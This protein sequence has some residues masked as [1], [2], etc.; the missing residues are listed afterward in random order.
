MLDGMFDITAMFGFSISERR[1]RGSRVGT[2]R[3]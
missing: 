1:S 3:T 2:M